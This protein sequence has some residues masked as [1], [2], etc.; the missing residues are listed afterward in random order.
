MSSPPT[1]SAW[2]DSSVRRKFQASLNHPNIAAIY[3]VEDRVLIME[4]VEGEAPKPFDD[5][6]IEL[7]RAGGELAR[8]SAHTQAIGLLDVLY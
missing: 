5:E 3:G 7:S 6:P 2:H 8:N 1:P 4:L